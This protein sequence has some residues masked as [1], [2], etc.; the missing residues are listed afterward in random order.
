MMKRTWPIPVSIISLLLVYGVLYTRQPG[1]SEA[2][3]L[4][5][6]ALFSIFALLASV[7][8]L[9]ASRMFEPGVASRRVWLFFSA[10]MTALTVSELLWIYYFVWGKEPP[11]PSPV[12]VLW[13]IGFLPVL[14]SLVLQYRALG[15][16]VSLRRKLIVS[17][18][19]LGLL[20]V[21]FGILWGFI[22]SNPGQVA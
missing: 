4:L 1:G 8:A 19:Y 9:R 11:Y 3:L 6:H 5:T 10:G 2:L 15:V 12:D 13:A 20:A 18:V 16:Q 17:A 21:A 14:A 22:L 7:L